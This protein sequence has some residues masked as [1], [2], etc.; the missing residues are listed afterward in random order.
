MQPHRIKVGA[1]EIMI[2]VDGIAADWGIQEAS[3]IRLCAKFGL[4]LITPEPGGKRYVGLYPFESALFEAHLPE[5]FRGDQTLV[6]SHMELA[7]VIY[8][9]TTA[10]MIRERV[11][12][13]AKGLRKGPPSRKGKSLKRPGYWT[14]KRL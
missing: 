5:A 9:H 1:S 4:P 7:G 8:G 12:A 13:I 2:S 6:R 14:D 11:L 10:Q 3:V